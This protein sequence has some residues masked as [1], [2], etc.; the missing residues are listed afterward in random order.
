MRRNHGRPRYRQ[1]TI[2]AITDA[3]VYKHL[4]A[5]KV[6]HT[7]AEQSRRT[8]ADGSSERKTGAARVFKID[9]GIDIEQSHG[10]DAVAIDPTLERASV[11]A[12]VQ[13]GQNDRR[14]VNP[15]RTDFH[16]VRQC[17]AIGISQIAVHADVPNRP[18]THNV[19][20]ENPAGA[21]VD[22][23]DDTVRFAVR[24]ATCRKSFQ[25]GRVERKAVGGNGVSHHRLGETAVQQDFAHDVLAADIGRKQRWPQQ[26]DVEREI[27]EAAFGHIEYTISGNA[28]RG[29]R[30]ASFYI[31]APVGKSHGEVDGSAWR[32]CIAN[33]AL[34]QNKRRLDVAFGSK[35]S[36]TRGQGDIRNRVCTSRCSQRAVPLLPIAL[37]VKRHVER[38]GAAR[39]PGHQPIHRRIEFQSNIETVFFRHRV[40]LH[41]QPVA[42][43]CAAGCGHYRA[44]IGNF[45]C[46]FQTCNLPAS[47]DCFGQNDA[48][49]F[50]PVDADVQIG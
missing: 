12:F 20:A 45:H 23:N 41:N 27:I 32:K 10:L 17:T 22:R 18:A 31:G 44:P 19:E 2:G 40:Q 50:Q 38:H 36:G 13:V 15:V 7:W 14:R 4:P 33:D 49:D 8:C 48:I 30:D 5:K 24:L 26:L 39:Q 9:V 29:R 21:R 1:Q 25:R 3:C 16:V 34:C 46:A 11:N 28:D 47:G 43:Q 37:A 6:L 35:S 42:L